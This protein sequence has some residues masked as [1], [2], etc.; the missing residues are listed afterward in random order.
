LPFIL[1]SAFCTLH[2]CSVPSAVVSDFEFRHSFVISTRHSLR[3]R[4]ARRYC[5]TTLLRHYV[6]SSPSHP[7][8]QLPSYPACPYPSGSPSVVLLSPSPPLRSL[9]P[10]RFRPCRFAVPQTPAFL[11]VLC[12]SVRPQSGR[13][14]VLRASPGGRQASRPARFAARRVEPAGESAEA[15]V[16]CFLCVLSVVWL[17]FFRRSPS[18]PLRSLRPLRFRPCRFAFVSDLELRHSIVIRVSDFVIGPPPSP[19][20]VL[21]VVWL[22]VACLSPSPPLRSLRPLRLRPA[23]K[24]R[25]KRAEKKLLT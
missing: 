10:L 16:L 8:T 1:H 25:A 14:L 6:T 17:C 2:C 3:R 11:C 12:P 19:L 21:S 18:P 24:R 23:C 13:D 20:C 4:Q 5:V 7:V 15:G 9:R 22:C